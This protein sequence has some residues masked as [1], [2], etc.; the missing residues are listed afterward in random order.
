MK[1]MGAATRG[2]GGQGE[3]SERGKGEMSCPC[4]V[5]LVHPP[6]PVATSPVPGL[7][8]QE[9]AGAGD[10]SHQALPSPN[11]P[12]VLIGTRW[13]PSTLVP[14]TAPV[15]S[16][17]VHCWLQSS[18]LLRNKILGEEYPKCRNWAPCFFAKCHPR[19]RG[20]WLLVQACLGT[21]TS[22]PC[23]PAQG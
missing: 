6:L 14:R 12:W 16:C 4:Q 22:L 15:L 5:F 9:A 2:V 1:W 17:C 19:G 10:L 18:C 3:Q 20:Y 23:T 11:L 13:G 8:W 7:D 21:C